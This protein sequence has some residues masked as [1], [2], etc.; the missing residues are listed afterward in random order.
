MSV[1]I[2]L[3]S[4]YEAASRINT[5]PLHAP[6]GLVQFADHEFGVGLPVFQNQNAKREG[7]RLPANGTGCVGLMACRRLCATAWRPA[8]VSSSKTIATAKLR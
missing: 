6:T 2:S 7:G 4:G 3:R 1:A 8:H 5:M